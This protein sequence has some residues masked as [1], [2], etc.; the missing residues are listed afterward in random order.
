MN[1]YNGFSYGEKRG[2]GG[3]RKKPITK[4]AVH[5]VHRII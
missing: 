3:E 2:E 4:R 1:N 5:I